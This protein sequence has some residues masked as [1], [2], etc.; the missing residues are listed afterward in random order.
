MA[1]RNALRVWRVENATYFK[2]A[3][4]NNEKKAQN[5]F[6]LEF[7]SRSFGYFIWISIVTQMSLVQSAL[8]GDKWV[9]MRV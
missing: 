3:L 1:Q 2:V 7:S 9:Q 5:E 6:I 8:S 4:Q